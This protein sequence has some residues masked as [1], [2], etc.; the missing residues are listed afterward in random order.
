VRP[1]YL[2]SQSDYAKFLKLN[3]KD[4]NMKPKALDR[5]FPY[6]SMESWITLFYQV[7]KIYY[8]NRVTPKSFK[9]LPGM[10]SSEA[11]VD[12]LMQQSNCYSVAECILLKWMQYHHNKMDPMHPRRL[13][14]FDK[15]LQDGHVF[16]SLVRSHFG[17]E[18]HLREMKVSCSTEDH[19]FYNARKVQESIR[20]IGLNIHVLP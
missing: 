19:Y 20:E 15:D 7:M 14:N 8:L 1:E 3:P 2:L 5:A 10:P 4:E 12:A 6:L 18:A 16:A 11:T 17:N 9:S 13:T